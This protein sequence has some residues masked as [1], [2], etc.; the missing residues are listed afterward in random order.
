MGKGMSGSLRRRL[1]HIPRRYLGYPLQDP[2][3]NQLLIVTVHQQKIL[4]FS[5][6]NITHEWSCRTYKVKWVR[7]LY[8]R[9]QTIYQLSAEDQITTH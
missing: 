7:W 2:Y 8:Q 9:N 5:G 1:S 6:C 4:T 3:K